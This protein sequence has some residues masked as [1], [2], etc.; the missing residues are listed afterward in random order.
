M[1]SEVPEAWVDC[2]ALL[3]TVEYPY[4]EGGLRELPFYLYIVTNLIFRGVD[5]DNS[6]AQEF[7]NSLAGAQEECVAIATPTYSCEPV[8]TC[9][10]MASREE[11]DYHLEICGNTRLDRNNDGVPCES[12]SWK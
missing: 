2:G 10:E 3:T 8:K 6:E 9:G 5:M 11:A 1:L 12:T 7:I 4:A